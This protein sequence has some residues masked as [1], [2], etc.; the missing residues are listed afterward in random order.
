MAANMHLEIV[1]KSRQ[2]SSKKRSFFDEMVVKTQFRQTGWLQKLAKETEAKKK[3]GGG[4]RCRRFFCD[5]GRQVEAQKSII[6][7][8]IGF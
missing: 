7:S 2:E 5:F 4:I 3:V 1:E 6:S 8:K